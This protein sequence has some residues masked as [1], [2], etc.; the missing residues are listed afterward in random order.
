ML[1]RNNIKELKLFNIINL[2]YWTHIIMI[3]NIMRILMI[4]Y[5]G[6]VVE[7]SHVISPGADTVQFTR[8]IG[9]CQK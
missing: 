6:E 2:L 5:I 4:L 7:Y 3:N 1:Y 9:R 8:I